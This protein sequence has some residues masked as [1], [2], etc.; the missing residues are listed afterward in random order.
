MTGDPAVDYLGDGLA[1][2]LIHRLSGVPQLRVAPRR[3]AFAYKGKDVDVRGIADALGVSY[4]VEGS[5]RRQ[6][7]VVRVNASLVDRATGTNRWSDSYAS[8][9][10][11][12]SI[13][14]KIGTQVLAA[15]ERVL[16]IDAQAAPAPP[17]V[18]DIAAHDFY[19]QGLSYLR[20]PRSARTLDA[21]EELFQRSLI[22]EPDFARAQA[23]LCQARVERYLLERVPAHVALAEESCEQAQVLDATA[24]EVHEAVG[25]LRLVTGN[26]A[27][28]EA[29]YRRALAIVPES[30]DALIGLAAAQADGNRPVEAEA[31]LKRA[32]ALQP[33]YAAS[34]MEY[35][36]LLF[37]QGR[38]QAAI[39]SYQRATSLEPDN[40]SALNNLGVAYL[41]VGDFDRSTEALSRALSI[42]PRQ[43]TYSNI[44]T[45]LYYRG[46]FGEAA[47]M[48]RKAIELAP[49]DHRLWGNLAD[50]LLFDGNADGARHAYVRAL[51]L[52]EGELAVNPNHGVNQAQTA[53]Y[54]S[55]LRRGDRAR[56]CIENALATG[57]SDNEMH[58]YVGLALLGLG[59]RE[60]AVLHV[61]RARELGRPDAF[62]DS[63]PELADIR[64]MI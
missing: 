24:Y 40:P 50:A 21:A 31:T 23:G 46:R 49:A 10:D 33:S 48:F 2:E 45:G 20:Q 37:Q 47:R 44:G 64:T 55:R 15:L 34:H 59:D 26:A 3:S 32:I 56:Q 61:Q 4:V 35:G 7:D 6:G 62:L 60:R 39:E 8:S 1:E 29:A 27:E 54:A 5:I 28:A 13:E 36:S 63:A 19:L 58:Y 17:S 51:E 30:P 18:G 25:N 14:D 38:A 57:E 9:G 43:A 22:K 11:Y 16:S 53:Y 52:A 42:Q 41:F 12:L